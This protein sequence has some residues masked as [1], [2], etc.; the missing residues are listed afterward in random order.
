MRTDDVHCRE[1]AG[2]GPV[3]LEVVPVTGAAF[4][5]ITVDQSVCASLSPHLLLVCGYSMLKVSFNSIGGKIVWGSATCL[6][7]LARGEA[8]TPQYF[9]YHRVKSSAHLISSNK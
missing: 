6:L 7:C 3:V 4:A 1:S 5:V 8:L 2:T 9:P